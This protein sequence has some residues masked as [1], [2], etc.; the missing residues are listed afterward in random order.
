MVHNS[1][2]SKGDQNRLLHP[3]QNSESFIKV[4]IGEVFCCISD[5]H[6][7]WVCFIN[8]SKL[9]DKIYRREK[10]IHKP[11]TISD[12]I[13]TDRFPPDLCFPSFITQH[14]KKKISKSESTVLHTPLFLIGSCYS[15]V[16]QQIAK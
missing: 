2:F 7:V 15:S 14:I 1:P 13:G 6:A 5:N 9:R 3:N 4:C 12:T 16:L 8:L 11:L 10:K